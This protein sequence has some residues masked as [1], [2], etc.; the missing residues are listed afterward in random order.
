VE[1]NHSSNCKAKIKPKCKGKISENGCSK[2]ELG[3]AVKFELKVTLKSCSKETFIISPIGLNQEMLVEIEPLCECPCAAIVG[4]V[5]QL[6]CGSPECNYE[7]HL[8]CGICQCCGN[9]YGNKCQCQNGSLENQRDPD[10]NCRPT[11]NNGTISR[12]GPLCYGRGDCVC[13]Q[14]VCDEQREGVEVTGQFCQTVSVC[15]HQPH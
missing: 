7:G 1:S 10:F 15:G 11:L 12:S 9:T 5:P 2:V 14:C 13:D 6:E 4:N 8:I 3:T